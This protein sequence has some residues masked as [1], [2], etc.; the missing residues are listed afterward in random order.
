M[1]QLVAAADPVAPH[2]ENPHLLSIDGRPEILR[3][4]GEHY[5]S[6]IRTDFEFVPYLD[7]LK[8]DGLNLTRVFLVGFREN[9]KEPSDDPLAVP[10]ARF[11]QPWARVHTGSTALDGLGKWDF[12]TWNEAYFTRL[13]EF[14]RACDER[15][16]IIDLTFFSTFY[17]E[18]QWRASPFHP[19]NNAQGIGPESR[20]DCYRPKDSG[21][22]EVQETVVREI[23]RRLN[24]FDNI[25]YNPWNEPFWNEPDLR[26]N[27]ELDFHRAMLAAIREEE[28][29]L[30]KKHLVG[31]NFPRWAPQ[32]D[33]FDIIHE[34]Y[35]IT[36]PGSPVRGAELLLEDRYDSGKVLSLNETDPGTADQARLEAWMFIL[37]G[38]AIY[39]G[40]DY[41][42]LIYTTDD[43][44]G[45]KPPGQDIRDGIRNLGIYSGNLDLVRL[46]RDLSWVVS[47][48]PDGATLQALASPGQQYIAYLHH[49]SGAQR[50]F[51][52]AYDPIDDAEQTASLGVNLPAGTW[53]A[54]WTRPSD[55][56]EL[57][58][59]TFV[60]EGG[61]RVLEPVI[62]QKDVALRI[63]RAD[64]AD[65]TPPPRPQSFRAT[66]AAD[67]SVTLDWSAVETFD[68]AEYRI[69]RREEG[70]E[71]ADPELP[72]AT[73]TPGD[74]SFTDDTTVA[75]IRYE[76]VL[77]AADAN[78]NESV[79]TAPVAVVPE[80]RNA[81]YPAGPHPLPGSIEAEDFDR[82]GPG[83][84]YSDTSAGNEGLAYRPDEDVDI[85]PNEAPEG[86]EPAG[87]HVTFIEPGEWLEFSVIVAEAGVF[88]PSVRIRAPD[89]GGT[90]LIASEETG[91]LGAIDIPAAEDGSEVDW[92]TVSGPE[93]PLSAGVHVIRLTFTGPDPGDR[94]GG[95]DRIDWTAVPKTPPSAVADVTGIAV[96]D[97]HD[98]LAEVTLDGTAS[99]AGAAPIVSH[100][101]TLG[102]AVLAET[103]TA[104]VFLPL[105]EHPIV[106][107][108]TDA[109]GLVSE[110][111]ST[112]RV[113]SPRLL[114]GG[115]ES[116]LDHW[117]V[118]D[119]V[120]VQDSSPY[121]ATDGGRLLSFNNDDRPPG[122]AVSQTIATV[123]GAL[124]QLS[125]DVGILAYN[126]NGQQLG[127]EVR[128]E[129]TLVETTHSISRSAGSNLRWESHSTFFTA[130]GDAATITFRDL[131]S[132][133]QAIDLLLD[134]VHLVQQISHTL[135]V[136]S[137]PFDSAVV[138]V[139]PGGNDGVT[140]FVRTFPNETMVTLS[141][142]LSL[143]GYRF[144]RWT[145]DGELF[146][147]APEVELLLDEDL[148]LTAEYV[149]GPPV[150]LT[151]PADT[152]GLENGDV[153]FSVT[154]EGTGTVV[155]QWRRD[156]AEIP[157]ANGTELVLTSVTSADEGTYDV[158]V[159][160]EAGATTSTPAVLTVRNPADF[161][162][163]G[164]EDGFDGWTTSGN[165]AIQ[166]GALYSAP[167][168]DFL[169][170]FNNGNRQPDGVLSREFATEPGGIYELS[171][172][173]GVLSYNNFTQTIGVEVTGAS[174]LLDESLAI[175][176]S[177]A[178][179]RWL[180]ASFVFTADSPLA[181]I[182]FRDLSDTTNGLD[183]LLDNIRIT[184]RI[185][186]T[187]EVLSTPFDG[188]AI[189][190]GSAD[191]AATPF[192]RS[193]QDG[194]VVTVEAAPSLQG[195]RFEK[196]TRDGSDLSTGRSVEITMD[197]DVSL[198]AIYIEGPPVIV[199]Q[200]S[201]ATV[202]EGEGATFSVSAEGTGTLVYQWRR[203]GVDIDGANTA[204]LALTFVTAEEEG[205]YD[206]V[207][208]NGAG[209][210]VSNAATLAV[211][212]PE[213]FSNGSFE[214]GFDGWTA[215]GSL[216]IQSGAPYSATE[217]DFLVSFN[218]GNNEPDGVLSREFTTEPGGIYEL[219]FDYGVLAYNNFVQ[220]IGVEVTGDGPLLSE[221]L[222]IRR[223]GANIRW[224]GASFV[225][226]ADSPLATITFRDLSDSTNGLDLLLDKVRV[227]QRISR[228]LDVASAP[229]DGAS[230][231]IGPDL[232]MTPLTL[233]Y[234][235]GAVV[236][237]EA[238]ASLQGYRF[239]K[240]T[241]D[242]VDFSGDVSIA[243]TMDADVSLTARYV[244]GP[245]VILTNPAD[246]VSP[247]GGD[248]TFSVVADGTGALVYQW[249]RDGVD[250][251]GGMGA[252][253]VLS[254]VTSGDEASYDV[255]VSNAAGS[256]TSAAATLTIQNADPFFNGSFEQGFDS[257]TVAGNVSLQQT[258][259]YVATN[260]NRLVA[261]NNGNSE[262]NGVLS[263]S[264]ATTPGAEY[265]LAFD[266]G[267][268]A[269]NNSAQ[270]LGVEL[271]GIGN[272]ASE[273]YPIS[274]IGGANI[275]W[276]TR[277][278]RFAADSAVT[279]LTFRDLSSTT[280][281]LDLT[282]D[283]VRISPVAEAKI[284]A[285]RMAL[286]DVQ[287][288]LP[289]VVATGSPTMVVHDQ[290]VTL[291]WI[292]ERPGR[293]FLQRSDNLRDWTTVD[294]ITVMEAGPVEL[295]DPEPEGPRMFY[296]IGHPR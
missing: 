174:P 56:T 196:W 26:D 233:F 295:A 94:S 9:T 276:E 132:S 154:A 186:R 176:R 232:V 93:I 252:E 261:F 48:M 258:G 107:A 187:L 286:A 291:T 238:P 230:V 15:G 229:F 86:G 202:A 164:F 88:R 57:H 67:G 222:E 99:T 49:G 140:P 77:T 28:A 211:R 54:A 213:D 265:D 85:E 168:G 119:P 90:W 66:P 269:Y 41:K 264:F 104:S 155:Y 61:V 199:S 32:L 266:F 255:V 180:G 263:R 117:T 282:L 210:T 11:L 31:H 207:V 250:I 110:T 208:S 204:E 123:P 288:P 193:Y 240:W 246:A 225:F 125:Y 63:D 241:R 227:T 95:L 34:H 156:G 59:E 184:Q 243:I 136:A 147:A 190:I 172:D 71:P 43:E 37:G 262:P 74:L 100:R 115:F 64:A 139:S 116:A 206:V 183:L 50:N 150:I 105:G 162:N 254:A 253:L 6:V 25:L 52:L 259:L 179:V 277:T 158:V 112:V 141:A 89:S 35:P 53:R 81:P 185:S 128:G 13:E 39:N 249:R 296:R 58:A 143:E 21:L 216:A 130:D 292:A 126:D 205:S 239:E 173:Y 247:D 169:V 248:V 268:L 2:P 33:G 30:P 142:P 111:A 188:A 16:I 251:A 62:Y 200:P 281:A 42:N 103:Q 244:E 149:E 108:V 114:D 87:H 3:T 129:G 209:S 293:H 96:D 182:A 38:G 275:R 145:R 223:S 120:D 79:A 175:R 272:L 10:P 279:T 177:G 273:A 219:S 192:A 127:V 69:Y 242:G 137:T 76:Y 78:G 121:Q 134:N 12:E 22:L 1:T 226:T 221:S 91:P 217:G 245:P 118:E 287:E 220:R 146:S 113:L 231:S 198:T 212:N 163:G 161:S 194:A 215:T 4:F 285:A 5:S 73:A 165:L 92:E 98:G 102:S 203:D 218:N 195:Y 278:I 283:H 157:G 138:S 72:F 171:F 271:A 83:V 84:A 47:G 153:T 60:H 17:T 270:R 197:T 29:E 257:W 122:G 8:R 45:S 20:Y 106:L 135:S 235:D 260:G 191:S 97:D 236:T 27:E 224:L 82:G 201:N 80:I 181:T 237:L 144:D 19:S 256:T 44:T 24:G 267:V 214:D 75:G 167:E 228:R 40:L 160:N 148:S 170:S 55:L 18:L 289:T 189:S 46:R 7:V 65:D 152:T 14:V 36:V 159:A 178:N 109:Y 290:T 234:Q 166:S 51:Q 124:Y 284:V 280:H 131:S 151:Q 133:T 23:V 68:L 70:V 101:W 294:E 274:R